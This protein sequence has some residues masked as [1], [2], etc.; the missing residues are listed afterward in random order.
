MISNAF[1][2]R[3]NTGYTLVIRAMYMW[4]FQQSAIDRAM[5]DQQLR[6]VWLASSIQ[7]REHIG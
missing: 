5:L 2:F 1:E 4:Q 6:G 7:L 3:F